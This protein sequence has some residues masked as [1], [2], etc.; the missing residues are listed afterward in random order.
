M[1]G[2]GQL[3]IN[4]CYKNINTNRLMQHFESTVFGMFSLDSDASV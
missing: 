2:Q 4:S 1:V 3:H